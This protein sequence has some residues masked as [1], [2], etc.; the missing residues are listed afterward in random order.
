MLRL[1]A[2]LSRFAVYLSPQFPGAR[3]PFPLFFPLL[4][5]PGDAERQEAPSPASLGPAGARP[6]SHGDALAQCIVGA[7]VWPE[8]VPDYKSRDP[9][10]PPPWPQFSSAAS[11]GPPEPGVRLSGQ[12][13][14]SFLDTRD[15]SRRGRGRSFACG[16]NARPTCSCAS[17]PLRASPVSPRRPAAAASVE[18]GGG[19]GN[20]RRRL[21]QRN[22]GDGGGHPAADHQAAEPE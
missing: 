2:N 13:P 18:R 22:G 21:P 5:G 20:P 1:P 17:R 14:V 4:Q 8:P 9:A 15:R 19:G 7:V 11:A 3:R 12:S 10:T 16:V 6:H